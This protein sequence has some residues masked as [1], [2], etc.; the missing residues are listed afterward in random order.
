MIMWLRQSLGTWSTVAAPH[1]AQHD[2]VIK[3]ANAKN[4]KIDGNGLRHARRMRGFRNT[5]PFH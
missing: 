5:P 2:E 1:I 4:G 3:R